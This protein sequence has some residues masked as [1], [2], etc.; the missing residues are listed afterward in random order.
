MPSVNK[1]T[2]P[3]HSHFQDFIIIEDPAIS[4][5][6]KRAFEIDK[7]LN[8]EVLAYTPP[9][10]YEKLKF[11]SLLFESF[12][13]SKA[14]GS[15][16]KLTD[17]K[18]ILKVLS[19]GKKVEFQKMKLSSTDA[20]YRKKEYLN[21]IKAIKRTNGLSANDI[22][23]QTI[24]E[25]HAVAS[26]DLDSFKETEGQK[27][28]I[29]R[30]RLNAD[31]IAIYDSITGEIIY[32]PPT[33]AIIEPALQSIFLWIK[34]KQKITPYDISIFHTL[35]Y[36]IHPFS[37]G[38]KRS[39]RILEHLLMKETG[40]NKHGFYNISFYYHEYI[41]RYY[42]YLLEAITMKQLRNWSIFF[43]EGVIYMLFDTIR[44]SIELER[45]DNAKRHYN[46]RK[47]KDNKNAIKIIQALSEKKYMQTKALNRVATISRQALI[48]NL[49]KLIELKLVTREVFM[50]NKKNQYKLNYES[51]NEVLLK[52]EIEKI[53][54]MYHR[55]PIG[56]KTLN[57][58]GL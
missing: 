13:I 50:D 51:P 48:S 41:E 52:D 25:L 42:K 33:E 55:I 22:S 29:G 28:N 6:E 20:L 15:S 11:R 7:R 4:I 32:E 47:I 16:L 3:K 57:C 23:I 2:L 37:N 5:L 45:L 26:H 54:D 21:I 18:K 44:K 49:N 36:S 27:Y 12:A 43:L 10:S 46:Y 53:I 24:K 17:A 40:L 58:L 30:L 19:Q 9:N 35:L 31:Q 38:N 34:Q 56:E 1:Y 8:E 14:E 39:V